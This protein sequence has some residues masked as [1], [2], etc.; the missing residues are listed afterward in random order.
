MTDNERAVERKG[1]LPPT[2]LFVAI[3]VMVALHV[4]LPG[5][6]LLPFPWNLLSVGPLGIGV[7]LDLVADRALKKRQTTVKPFEESSVLITDGVYR[8]SRNPMYLGFVLI[9]LGIGVFMGSLIP[10][11]I[12]PILAVLM[13]VVFIRVEERM[14]EEKFGE[15]WVRYRKQVRRWI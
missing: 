5:M 10:F 6:K 9:L 14:L 1:P 11:A 8:I 15:R 4:L 3:V 12:I 13:D 7:A 2:Y